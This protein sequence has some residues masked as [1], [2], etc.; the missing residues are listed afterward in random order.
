MRGYWTRGEPGRPMPARTVA[1]LYRLWLL[2]FLLK[3][4]GSSWDISWHFT[5]FRD[6][7]AT[8][9]DINLI[10]TA[11]AV[12]GVI[13]HSYTG[14]G[15]DRAG[16]RLVQ[17][18]M[19][20]FIVAAPLDELNH[21]INGLD[22]TAWSPSHFLLYTGT[23]IMIAGV[24]R[25]LLAYV[26]PGRFRTFAL[27]AAYFFFFENLVFPNMQQEYG[28][29][30]LQEF[31]GGNPP[32]EPALYRFAADSLGRASVGR[33]TI[34][35]FALPI[36]SW[37]YPVYGV[38]TAALLLII[39]RRVVGVRWSATYIATGYVAYRCLTWVILAS[40]GFARSAV[41]FWLVVLGVA[42]DMVAMGTWTWLVRIL[43]GFAVLT[44]IG[45][46]AIALQSAVLVAPPTNY[47]TVPVTFVLLA[48]LWM[49]AERWYLP[50]VHRRLMAFLGGQRTPA[51]G[52]I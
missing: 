45:Y 30:T 42:V 5:W 4:L 49:T 14:Y 19:G 16:L 28:I 50:D 29:M 15:M 47:Y 48:A 8:P 7:F 39:A 10:G 38:L 20:I 12:A 11:L 26:E 32:G 27:T 17:W 46:T 1:L 52:I 41:P 25:G 43:A 3:M 31:D 6:T 18:G 35:S 24:I 13:F 37:F 9:H 36:P 21:R 34:S 40:T 33:D 44:G 22:I 23:A 51:T 2:A